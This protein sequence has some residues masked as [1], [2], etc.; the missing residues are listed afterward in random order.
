MTWGV[1]GLLQPF[2]YEPSSAL[3][4][5]AFAACWAI[6]FL[7]SGESFAALA[8]PPFTPP[9]LPSATAA[10]FFFLGLAGNR[11]GFFGS[12]LRGGP[13]A[14]STTL[15]AFCAT[16]PLLERLCMPS[17]C[18]KPSA[19]SRP[20]Q[21]DSLP[22]SGAYVRATRRDFSSICAFLRGISHQGDA[23]SSLLAERPRARIL[24]WAA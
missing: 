10:G 3:A 22:V 8:R 20:F 19:K 5:R 24:D 6:A 7:L 2:F 1:V 9:S 12:R 14:S 15:K 16:S 13:I 23:A 17:S 11:I 18:H 21:T 4:Q